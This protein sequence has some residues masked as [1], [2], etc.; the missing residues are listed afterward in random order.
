MQRR[1]DRVEVVGVTWGRGG[2][3]TRW[4]SRGRATERGVIC[5]IKKDIIKREEDLKMQKTQAQVL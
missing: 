3:K 2:G 1:Q 5:R 4:T